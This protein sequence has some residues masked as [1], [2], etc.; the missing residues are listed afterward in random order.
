MALFT[1]RALTSH[2]KSEKGTL[3]AASAGEAKAILQQ[4]QDFPLEVKP[5]RP[6]SLGLNIPYLFHREPRLS[7]QG[8]ASFTRQF[9]TLLEA[10]IPYDASME[11]IL[12]QSSE[13][14][15]K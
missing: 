10:T 14:C 6:F 9:A 11:M 2:G 15:F 1:Y 13:L 5:S 4:R 12:Q 7:V 8:L 3:D